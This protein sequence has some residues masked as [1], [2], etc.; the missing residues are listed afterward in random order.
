MN[1]NLKNIK[2]VPSSEDMINIIFSKT[3]RKTPTVVHPGY[4]ISKY[5]NLFKSLHLIIYISQFN[6]DLKPVSETF[7]CVKS[8]T[9]KH[10]MMKHYL[11]Y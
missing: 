9:L 11:L 5:F 4:S 1:Y 10:L 8:N 3:Q 2:P 7:T 6:I